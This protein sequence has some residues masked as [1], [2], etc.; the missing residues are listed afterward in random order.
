MG[1]SCSDRGILYQ[2]NVLLVYLDGYLLIFNLKHAM[3]NNN[4]TRAYFQ[5]F[6]LNMI[7]IITIIIS[8]TILLV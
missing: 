8:I 5:T 1:S 2:D 6:M 3:S 7:V 4:H